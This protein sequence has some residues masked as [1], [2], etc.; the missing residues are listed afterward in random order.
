MGAV[1]KR[2]GGAHGIGV[3]QDLVA[4]EAKA[5][6]VE[7]LWPI[8]TVGVMSAGPEALD[9][10]VP[11]EESL[12]DGGLELDDLHWLDVVMLVEEKQLDGRGIP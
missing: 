8:N 11:E 3:D 10:Y 6:T 5:S 2:F 7:I 9:M 12:V 4:V 1:E